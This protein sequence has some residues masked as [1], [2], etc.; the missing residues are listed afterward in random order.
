MVLPPDL[1]ILTDPLV[2]A[3]AGIMYCVEFF[4]DKV[5][6]VDNSWDALHTFITS[7]RS[8]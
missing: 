3:A 7:K 1:Q 5:P 6:G 4:A 8:S 2:M